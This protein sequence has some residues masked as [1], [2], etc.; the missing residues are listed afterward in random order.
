MASS[1]TYRSTIS[2][3]GYFL[4]MRWSTVSQDVANN[5]SS[6][7]VEL[8]IDFA[9]RINSTASKTASITING[10]TGTYSF[11]IGKNSSGV[12]KKIAERTVAVPHNSDGTKTVALSAYAD[13][14]VSL[15]G[16]YVNRA[17]VSGSPTLN[18]IPRASS[19]SSSPSSVA[20]NSS[21]KYSI[22][23][24]SSS[25]THDVKF[26]F[27]SNTS[28]QTG[29]GTSGTFTV[30]L[31]WLNAIPN[32][33]SGTMTVLL[34]TKNGSTTVG[35]RSYSVRVSAP[36][37]VV[38]TLSGITA[39]RVN[40]SVPSAWA[41]YVQNESQA[42]IT[43]N[44]P[45]GVYGSTIKSY[46]VKMGTTSKSGSSV[47]FD[48]PWSGTITF[49]GTV[50]DS[51]GR[52]TSKTTSIKVEP[53]SPPQIT[54]SD[55]YRAASTGNFNQD[56]TYGAAKIDYDYSTVGGSNTVT[57]LV[58]YKRTTASTW[59]SGG[60]FTDNSVQVFGSGNIDTNNEYN[61][62]AKIVDGLGNTVWATDTLSTAFVTMDILAEGKGVSFGKVASQDG[63]LE[64]DFIGQF[65]NGFN[66]PRIPAG[67]DLNDYV[68]TGFFYSPANVDVGSMTNAP[69]DRSAGAL[70]V[71]D[72]SGTQQFWHSYHDNL[73]SGRTWRR[74]Y[75]SGSWSPWEPSNRV[76]KATATL[77][78]GWSNYGGTFDPAGYTLDRA[79]RV[80]LTG[81]V[82]SGSIDS[83]IM[84]L[85]PQ[86]RPAG[87]L[88]FGCPSW[89]N[90]HGYVQALVYVY[91]NGDVT[92][93]TIGGTNWLS[94]SGISFDAVY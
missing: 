60:T 64:S 78:N 16:S 44:S 14:Q 15:N 4:E 34:T 57:T 46:S 18:T 40:N 77:L 62:R 1:G 92:P 89:N 22:S 3:P 88:I 79:N 6:V 49:T 19:F 25:F 52:S 27:G 43:F 54:S 7:K 63:V 28:T 33:S 42:T 69:P 13:V 35:S 2:N 24:A 36:S 55:F 86:C 38:P 29:V 45:S 56:G 68:H 50:T 84:T 70:V 26:T 47:K 11:V 83:P 10:S 59:T 94:L 48:L 30:P 65:N 91:S 32:S 93:T 87:N 5:R 9:Y 81:L 41:K 61:V 39:T 23:R 71:L 72:S 73:T 58:E 82:R 75:Y 53:Y 8:W 80:H 37:T 12:K 74:R 31:S 90:S 17:S 20:A 66:S 76:V 21:W 85:P 67:A 51:R